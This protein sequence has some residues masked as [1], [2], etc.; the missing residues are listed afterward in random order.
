MLY[1]ISEL[2]EAENDFE[3]SFILKFLRFSIFEE[4]R[5]SKEE[6]INLLLRVIEETKRKIPQKFRKE[7]GEEKK[8]KEVK[9]KEGYKKQEIKDDIRT[10]ILKEKEKIEREISYTYTI[11]STLAKDRNLNNIISLSD[12]EICL[13]KD[14]ILSPDFI[15]ILSIIQS[16]YEDRVRVS[17]GE[18]FFIR[19]KLKVK[20]F[21]SALS[22][23][24]LI[25]ELIRTRMRNQKSQ[26]EQKLKS[27]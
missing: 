14:V 3:L 2:S 19:V 21:V 10:R 17:V 26:R 9:E 4:R 7:K 15:Y 5:K 22:V 23:L 6:A 20:V 24:K 8:E 11:I 1:I 16:I 25:F 13:N 12:I 27:R 18:K